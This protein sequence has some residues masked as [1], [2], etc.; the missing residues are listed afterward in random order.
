MMEY[1]QQYEL[2]QERLE[3]EIIRQDNCY[4]PIDEGREN[5]AIPDSEIEPHK[6]G[7]TGKVKKR[8]RTC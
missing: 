3:Y 5:H 7:R 2:D 8:G 6:R 1:L 4:R